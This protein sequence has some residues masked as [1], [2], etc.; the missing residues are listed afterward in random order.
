[1]FKS[2]RRRLTLTL[3][4]VLLSA[5]VWRAPVVASGNDEPSW[6]DAVGSWF[7]RAVPS[8]V[9]CPPGSPGCPIPAEIIMLFTI[10]KDGTFVG[11]DSNI[12]AGGN[13]T[14]AHGQW[15]RSEARSIKGS[16]TFLQASPAG[17][18][19]GGFKNLFHATVV[20]PDELEGHFEAFLYLYTTPTG[21]AILGADGLP[22][23]SPL[24]PPSQCAT[25]PGCT[26]LGEFTFSVK[27]VKT[28]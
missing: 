1:M 6:N 22:T 20:N 7:G 11:T 27:R 19:I 13:H 5:L 23:P 16:Y 25:T 12:F 8:A 9:I 21:A 26:R 28:P 4:A 10:N 24:A 17:V 14:T 18:L 2:H 3:T 15:E